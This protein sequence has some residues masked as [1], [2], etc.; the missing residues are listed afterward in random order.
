MT[1][2]YLAAKLG[3]RLVL[4]AAIA[5]AA[6]I[7]S[8]PRP[9]DAWVSPGAAAA[10]GLGS[11]ALG[12]MLGAGANPYYSPYYPDGYYACLLL[13]A[14]ALLLS[15]AAL[16]EPLLRALL[17]LLSGAEPGFKSPPGSA[18]PAVGESPVCGLRE[19]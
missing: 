17:P 12:T 6:A 5:G 11:F 19:G 14:S 3:R 18:A 16:L 4:A 8:A 7:A 2:G 15:A 9:A 13:S 1:F 10:I